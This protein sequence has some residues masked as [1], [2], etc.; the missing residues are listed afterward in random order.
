MLKRLRVLGTM[1]EGI[2]YFWFQRYHMGSVWRKW[3]L[4]DPPVSPAPLLLATDG[5]LI[6]SNQTNVSW[7]GTVFVV[8]ATSNRVFNLNQLLVTA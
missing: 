5:L 8:V 6:A 2:G 4:S 1:S 3:G 7:Y